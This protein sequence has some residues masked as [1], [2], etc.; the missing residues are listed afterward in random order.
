MTTFMFNKICQYH[1]HCDSS[2]PDFR[3]HSFTDSPTD[4]D[5]FLSPDRRWFFLVDYGTSA[6]PDDV[7]VLSYELVGE[8]VKPLPGLA[9]EKEIQI[10]LKCLHPF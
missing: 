9:E 10:K 4:K 7:P 3:C 2:S 1:W 8:S 6:D 5:G